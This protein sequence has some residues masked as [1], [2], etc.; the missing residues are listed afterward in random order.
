[1]GVLL[2]ETLSMNRYIHVE[3]LR[4]LA[5]AINRFFCDLKIE[6]FQLKVNQHNV[7]DFHIY[8][9]RSSLG[10]YDIQ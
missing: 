4:K 1:M 3:A 8:V 10:P 6:N 7:S 2:P 5:R 9:G